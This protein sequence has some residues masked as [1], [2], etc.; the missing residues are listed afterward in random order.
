M[1]IVW[2]G[3]CTTST[4]SGPSTSR[5]A[6]ATGSFSGTA[7][8]RAKTPD[9][10]G[11][12]P[13]RILTLRGEISQAH[14]EFPEKLDPSRILI[15]RGGIIVPACPRPPPAKDHSDMAKLADCL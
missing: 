11:F 1:Y 7:S 14:R 10:R 2:P 3:R 9:F 5:R 4:R 15:L 12:G 8:L 13:S 6:P